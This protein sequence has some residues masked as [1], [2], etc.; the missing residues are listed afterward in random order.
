MPAKTRLAKGK[1]VSAPEGTLPPA[2]FPL[3]TWA[4]GRRRIPSQARSL[5]TR[6]VILESARELANSKGVGS[7]TMQM[8][9]KKFKERE[10]G[11]YRGFITLTVLLGIVF[12]VTQIMGFSAL[13]ANSIALTGP[14]SNSASSF[15]L[16]I[17]GLHILHVVGGVIALAIIFLRAYSV[18]TK[19]YNALPV[20]LASIYWHF[21]DILWIYLFVFLQFVG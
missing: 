19:F 8:A 2:P 20:E 17:A 7:V 10:M 15:L 12:V 21:V 14:R 5:R 3:A 4:G 16:V 13:E 9:L 1:I 6:G 11:Q 18:K